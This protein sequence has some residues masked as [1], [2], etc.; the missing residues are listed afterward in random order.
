MASGWC[1]TSSPKKILG[2]IQVSCPSEEFQFPVRLDDFCSRALMVDLVDHGDFHRQ[3][4]LHPMGSGPRGV[5]H[6]HGRGRSEC[7]RRQRCREVLFQPAG[8]EPFPGDLP[9]TWETWGGLNWSYSVET[10]LVIV[11]IIW[12]IKATLGLFFSAEVT[13]WRAVILHLKSPQIRTAY[14][15]LQY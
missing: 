11:G 7:F 14:C 6:L 12:H 9:E 15:S 2:G 10:R 5:S 4:D 1:Q 3:T 13:G 8:I